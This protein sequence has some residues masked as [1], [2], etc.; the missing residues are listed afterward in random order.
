MTIFPC[1]LLSHVGEDELGQPRNP[2][3]VHLELV[4]GVVQRRLLH[5]AEQSEAG[6]VDEDVD[7]AS[8]RADPLDAGNEIFF[9]GDVHLEGDGSQV[10][11]VSH[12]LDSACGGIDSVALLKEAYG[13]VLAYA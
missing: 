9:P 11:E 4:P 10:F 1:A 13:G 5:R 8:F 12:L 3:Q 2:E 6:V 7:A